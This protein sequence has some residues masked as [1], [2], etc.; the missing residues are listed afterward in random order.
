MRTNERMA[1][2]VSIAGLEVAL[3]GRLFSMTRA[4]AVERIQKAGGRHAKEP[5]PATDILVAGEASGHLTAAGGISRNLELF[6]RLKEGGARARL[7][8]EPEFL[9]MI[10]ADEELEDFSRLYTA[11][12]VSRIVEAPLSE[13]RAWVR[14]GLLQP[15]RTSRRLAWFEFKDILTARSLSRLTAAGV[16]ASRIHASLTE[17]A[18]WLPDGERVIGRLEAYA[19]GL[20]A[21]LPDGSWVEPSGQRLMDFQKEDAAAARVSAFPTLQ[22]G[23]WFSRAIEAEE[24]G[25]LQAA[26]AL[27]S[28]ALEESPDSE[29]Y[30]NLG[31]VL[32]DL[33]RDAEAAERYLQAIDADHEFV[34]AWNNLGNSMAALGKLEDA[35]HAYEMALSLEP[36]YPDPHCNLAI[37][38]ERLGRPGRVVGH[39]TVCRNTFPSQAHLT[40]LRH[41]SIDVEED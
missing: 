10:G 7:I 9:R 5:G 37:V 25:N 34:E 18:R 12:Q 24:R 39:S 17:L 20:R 32:Y 40:L 33:G 19:T 16:P 3:T 23:E 29:T 30:F 41:P 11:A 6:R 13:V 38:M 14:K 15:A 21:R 35:V 36:D 4:E 27:Y 31:N 1:E 22:D 2:A 8:E 26:A 28:K